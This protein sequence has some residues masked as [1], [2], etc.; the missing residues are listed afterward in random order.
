V[1]GLCA[2]IK[3]FLALFAVYYL[4]ARRWTELRAIVATG[5]AT[6][7]AGV[8][9][10]GIDGHAAWLD[11]LSRVDWAWAAMNASFSGLFARTMGPNPYFEPLVQ[12][13]PWSPVLALGTGV[14]AGVWSLW[15]LARRDV[16]VTAD[17][18][19]SGV[20]LTALLVSP[21][22]W[23]YYIFIAVGPV[24]AIV[25]ETWRQLPL[26]K[27]ALLSSCAVGLTLPLPL[28]TLGQ[29]HSVATA[30]IGSIY[31]WTLLALWASTLPAVRPDA[32]NMD[33]DT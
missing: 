27:R 22:G 12:A 15:R 9:V 17:W 14:L 16:S 18:V 6:L 3:P 26:W 28:V 23:F 1:L 10:F 24:T 2:G 11:S 21:L 25:F 33:T 13:E 31:F 29:G 19:F 20:L 5:G 30:T 32:N 8:L 4:V 7:V